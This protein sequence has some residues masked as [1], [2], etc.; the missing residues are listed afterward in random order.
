MNVCTVGISESGN[1]KVWLNE[2]L[3]KNYA[4][5]EDIIKNPSKNLEL[6]IVNNLVRMLKAKVYN[7][8]VPP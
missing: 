3:A 4:E 2:N 7:N 5:T 6:A 1:T 8:D